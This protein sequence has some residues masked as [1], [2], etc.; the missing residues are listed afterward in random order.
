MHP[1]G[2]MPPGL[3][4]SARTWSK[5]AL[6]SWSCTRPPALL[7]GERLVRLLGSPGAAGQ[8][9][10]WW[11][12]G[13]G[14]A[15]FGPDRSLTSDKFDQDSSAKGRGVLPRGRYTEVCEQWSVFAVAGVVGL[16]LSRILEVAGRRLSRSLRRRGDAG[17]GGMA[18][19]GWA[20]MPRTTERPTFRTVAGR[21]LDSPLRLGDWAA[22]VAGG[23]SSGCCPLTDEGKMFSLPS[24]LLP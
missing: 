16:S 21:L 13:S 24:S 2:A 20:V 1:R 3:P 4:P 14:G 6:R 12:C 9:W 22:F 19:R 7:S 11:N 10:W 5:A 17:D 23:S 8:R 18:L 15:S